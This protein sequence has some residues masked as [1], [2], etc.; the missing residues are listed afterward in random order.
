MYASHG[1]DCKCEQTQTQCENHVRKQ[2]SVKI[3][4]STCGM[5]TERYVHTSRQQH[6]TQH[7]ITSCDDIIIT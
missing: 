1:K 2:T 7:L 5:C 3:R 6:I 4:K